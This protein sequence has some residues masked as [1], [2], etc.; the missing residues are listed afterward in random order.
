MNIH[1]RR[2][3]LVLECAQLAHLCPDLRNYATERARWYLS[4]SIRELYELWQFL[5]ETNLLPNVECYV[6]LRNR[7]QKYPQTSQ[8][9]RSAT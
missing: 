2:M 6:A 3:L 4:L 5:E 1:D 7:H 8:A 9:A